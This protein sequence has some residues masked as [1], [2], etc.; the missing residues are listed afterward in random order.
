MEYRQCKSYVQSRSTEEKGPQSPFTLPLPTMPDFNSPCRVLESL[1]RIEKLGQMHLN[2]HSNLAG[3]PNKISVTDV[4]DLTDHCAGSDLNNNYSFYK[5]LP[6]ISSEY[7]IFPSNYQCNGQEK[8]A[9]TMPLTPHMHPGCSLSRRNYDFEEMS[10]TP[11]RSVNWFSD[12]ENNPNILNQSN[13]HGNI[14][15]D[16][17]TSHS[18]VLYESNSFCAPQVVLK[19]RSPQQK[20]V[21]SYPH[22]PNLSNIDSPR[23]SGFKIGRKTYMLPQHHHYHHHQQDLSR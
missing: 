22:N 2:V 21:L 7:S 14:T 15:P 6:Q 8:N 18:N 1:E 20:R 10:T 17:Q 13:N 23:Q 12:E 16:K 3:L 9:L 11:L 4:T 5:P 19:T